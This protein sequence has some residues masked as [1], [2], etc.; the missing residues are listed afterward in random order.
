M[1]ELQRKQSKY[2]DNLEYFTEQGII[3]YIADHILHAIKDQKQ[4]DD[5][6]KEVT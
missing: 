2:P 6:I 1:Y 5:E 3:K 4:S